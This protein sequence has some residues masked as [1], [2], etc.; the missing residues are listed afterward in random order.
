MKR[1]LEVLAFSLLVTNGVAAP[2]APGKPVA[3]R[4][5]YDN[6]GS[7]YPGYQPPGSPERHSR[8]ELGVR[9]VHQT[10]EF[11]SW[12]SDFVRAQSIIGAR[13]VGM[14]TFTSNH[15]F[16]PADLQQVHPDV[17]VEQ[18]NA[19]A[20]IGNFP[21]HAGNMT[22]LSESL[23]AFTHDFT[24]IVWL[25]TDNIVETGDGQPDADVQQFFQMLAQRPELRS[26]HLFKY[27]FNDNGHTA[28]LA[29][30]GIVVCAAEVPS[31]TLTYYDGRFRA[32]RD[33][34]RRDGN[35]PADLFAGREYLKLKDLRVAPMQPELRLVL[36]EGDKGTF[37]EGQ[38]VQLRVEGAIRSLLTQ[39]SVTGG[40]YELAISSPFVP[41]AWAQRKL[42]AKTLEPQVFDLAHGEITE[43][44][45]PMASRDVRERLRSAQPVSFSPSGPVEWLRL[46]WS[47]A[48][49]RYSATAQMSFSD[50]RVR[51]EPQQMAGIFGI[52]HASSIFE[53]QNVKTL[54]NV[55]PAIVPVTFALRTGTKRTA[56]LLVILSLLAVLAATLL[57]LLTRRQVFRISYSGVPD[58]ITALRRLGRYDVVFD[59]KR[60]GR[61]WRGLVNGYG[62]DAVRGDA[63]LTVVPATDEGAWDVRFTGGGARRLSIK[64]DGGGKA[65]SPSAA[66]PPVRV[67]PPPP[68]PRSASP[69][70]PPRSARR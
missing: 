54:A 33:A 68:P 8:A 29:V 10:P 50:V 63:A 15:S 52:D 28:G 7:M 14:W 58:R 49:V 17:P 32:L 19:A 43:P 67:G 61:L 27:M 6:S 55:P 65:K 38:S 34:K 23:Q 1:A 42:G 35:P 70:P 64:A 66:K 36:E 9:Y 51:L 56:I 37:K 16:T 46:A 45:A 39:H 41:E 26:V 47:G 53:F 13:S 62:F 18:F 5:L 40:R 12:L 31:E 30:Y 44:I 25:I 21:P 20:A 3:V 48:A 60:L 57:Y 69:P 2:L 24:G 11:A 22:F 59:G 4:I